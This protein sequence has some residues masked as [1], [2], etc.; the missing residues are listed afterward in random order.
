M[1]KRREG[2]QKNKCPNSLWIDVGHNRQK[3]PEF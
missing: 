1:N 3:N 2:I